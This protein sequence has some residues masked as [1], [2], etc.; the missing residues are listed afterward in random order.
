MGNSQASSVVRFGVFEAD[1]RAGELR[2]AGF[3]IRLQ[4][5]PFKILAALLERPGTML[6]REELRQRI[7]PAESFGDFDHAIDLAVGK[8]RT[9]LGDSASSPHFVETLPRR[10]YRFIFPVSREV[11]S[12][13]VQPEFTPSDSVPTADTPKPNT[14][15]LPTRATH[16]WK[17]WSTT[18]VILFSLVAIAAFRLRTNSRVLPPGSV[19]VAHFEN[20]T[21]EPALDDTL[22][23]AMRRELSSSEF[24][25]VVPSERV[26]DILRLMKKPG[27]SPL[28][29]GLAREVCVR[30]GAIQELVTGQVEK[31]GP[32]YLLSASIVDPSNGA[33]LQSVSQEAASTAAVSGA[34]RRLSNQVRNLAGESLAQIQESNARLEQA[35]TPSLR[36]LKLY[37]QGMVFVNE[38]KWGPGAHLLEQAVQADS[39]FAS[40]HVYLAYCDSQLG[41]G[42]KAGEH[43]RRAFELADTATD[44]ERYFI[45]GSYYDSTGQVE[46]AIQ[47]YEVLVRLYPDHYW[48]ENNL[49]FGYEGSRRYADAVAETTKQAQLRPN[50]Y[51]VNLRAWYAVES[52]TK[53]PDASR[54]Y[55]EAATRLEK[56]EFREGHPLS[57]DLAFFKAIRLLREGNTDEALAEADRLAAKTADWRD[58]GYRQVWLD[59]LGDLYLRCGKIKLAESF[60]RQLSD[61]GEKQADLVSI[62]QARGDLEGLR[63]QMRKQFASGAELG[64]GTAA[65]LAEAGMLPVAREVVSRLEK[66]KSPELW[67]AHAHGEVDLANGRTEQGIQ[68]LQTALRRY[69]NDHDPHRYMAGN[70]LAQA[71]DQQGNTNGAIEILQPMLEPRSGERDDLKLDLH[72]A[73]LY[74]KVGREEEA[75]R[76]EARVQNQLAY[77]DPDDALLAELQHHGDPSKRI[78][79]NYLLFY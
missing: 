46:Q 59:H 14:V 16:P 58:D 55:Y 69:L 73:R 62:A 29:A 18:A 70:A 44:R 32:V 2:K 26:E 75:E 36:A 74:R 27:N 38:E 45:Q 64:P 53:D 37:S 71:L 4:E 40:A 66:Q 12:E 47:A 25:K 15:H 49:Q 68:E 52:W 8:L 9:A 21:G 24:L 65:R 30:D 51:L 54:P 5:Q 3:R 31:L 23:Y 22:E 1:L 79:A 42:K 72:L 33:I 20:L 60:Y 77:A 28:D 7:W 50:D 13:T 34:V 56:P 10:G 48:G 67:L 6:T 57:A 63:R 11:N 17:L 19:L 76:L 39:D 41:H 35:T 43:F 78:P 61:E